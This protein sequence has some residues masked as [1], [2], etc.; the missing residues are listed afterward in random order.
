[1]S[2][3]DSLLVT[4]SLDAS[5]FKAGSQ[6]AIGYQKAML[7]E[8]HRTANQMESEGA[9][10]AA[11]FGKIKTEALSLFAVLIGGRGI[12]SIVKNTVGGLAELNRQA[13]SIGETPQNLKAF[14]ATIEHFGGTAEGATSALQGLAAAKANALLTGDKEYQVAAGVFGAG[15]NTTPIEFIKLIE[16]QYEKLKDQ[17]GGVQRFEALVNKIIPGIDRSTLQSLEQA[18]SVAEF[19]KEFDTSY[20]RVAQSDAPIKD[21]VE[22]KAAWTDLENSLEAGAAK[23]VSDLD[24]ALI[25]VTNALLKMSDAF[26]KA[27]AGLLAV[28]TLGGALV[29]LIKGPAIVKSWLGGGAAAGAGEAAAGAGEAAAAT[30]LG[31]LTTLLGRLTLIGTAIATTY[32]ALHISGAG[33]GE[34]DEINRERQIM[35]GGGGDQSAPR[36]I[37]NNNPGNLEFA[38]QDGATLEPGGRFARFSTMAQGVAA[39][40]HQLQIYASRGNDTIAG[41][42]AKYAPSGE[43]DTSGYVAHVAASTGFGAGQHLDLNDPATLAK[44]EHAIIGMENGSRYAGVVNWPTGLPR[45]FPSAAAATPAASSGGGPQVTINTLNV[46][47]QATDAR[48]ISR[49]IYGAL[50]IQADRGPQ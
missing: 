20:K 29:A 17:P 30:A 6:Q 10:A 44:V 35:G 3:V 23:L 19:T 18:K 28:G 49:D 42:I 38:G 25:L 24:P 50:V 5:K 32:E 14:E 45:V 43:N 41:I 47:T 22:L 31:G 33:A 11:F 1:M 40:G 7:D 37:R 34:Q 46:N 15:D 2:L 48:G 16:A 9:R 36:G 4:L 39:L 8:T 26:P 27:T 12:E 21:A 13:R